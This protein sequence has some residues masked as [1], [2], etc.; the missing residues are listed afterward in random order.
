MRTTINLKEELV[1]DLMKRTKSRTKT[2]AI[3]T[4]IKE[5]LQKKA[6][7]DLIALSGKVDIAPDWQKEEEAE[8]DEYKDHC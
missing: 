6:I 3:E 1:R 5:Y 2:H 8:L 4:A 7:E